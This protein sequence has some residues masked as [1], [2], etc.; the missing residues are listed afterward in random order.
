M[1]FIERTKKSDSIEVSLEDCE[2]FFRDLNVDKTI[3]SK[4]DNCEGL[5]HPSY[6][7]TDILKASISDEENEEIKATFPIFKNIYKNF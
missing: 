7:I 3:H 1:V 6:D 2:E 4:R 5:K